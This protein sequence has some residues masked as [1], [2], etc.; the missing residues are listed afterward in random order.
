MKPFLA[1]AAAPDGVVGH[2]YASRSWER[3]SDSWRP[4]NRQPDPLCYSRIGALAVATF[5]TLL[6]FQCSTAS[7]VG[8]EDR[9][10]GDNAKGD[11]VKTREEDVHTERGSSHTNNEAT[12]LVIVPAL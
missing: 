5:I 6:W 1:L 11:I 12:D 8:F 9:E 2:R 10:M 4:R 3:L 7:G